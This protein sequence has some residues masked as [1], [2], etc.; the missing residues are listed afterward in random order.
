MFVTVPCDVGPQ[1]GTKHVPCHQ[2]ADGDWPNTLYYTQITLA[3]VP[4]EGYRM[5]SVVF[6]CMGKKSGRKILKC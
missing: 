5:I 6:K 4:N 3:E 1:G 2:K